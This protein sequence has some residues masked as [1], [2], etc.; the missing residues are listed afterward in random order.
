[1]GKDSY[2][3]VEDGVVTYLGVD[4]NFSGGPLKAIDEIISQSKDFV[5]DRKYCDFFG[6]NATF[7]PNG[8]LKRIH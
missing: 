1:M 7:N 5:I 8:Y 3:I 6:T 4:G 2:Y